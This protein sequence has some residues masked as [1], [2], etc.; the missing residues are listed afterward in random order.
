MSAL[1]TSTPTDDGQSRSNIYNAQELEDVDESLEVD[2]KFFVYD[3]K[4][5]FVVNLSGRQWLFSLPSVDSVTLRPNHE[6]I[7]YTLTWPD[8]KS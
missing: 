3:G 7:N 1:T 5:G 6:L 8:Q 2:S 4:K